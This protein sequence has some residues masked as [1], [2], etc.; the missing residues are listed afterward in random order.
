MLT[1]AAVTI[2]LVTTTD[3]NQTPPSLFAQLVTASARSDKGA[4]T[5]LLETETLST[6]TITVT[7]GNRLRGGLMLHGVSAVEITTKLQGCAV[8][9]WR[10]V[11][12]QPKDAFVL[13]ECPS[14]R[15]PRTDCYFYSYR[16]SMLDTRYHPGNLFIHEM[17]SWDGRCGVR[18][19]PPPQ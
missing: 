14:K 17:P 4:L 13:W 9:R 15:V 2:L 10:D 19:P 18:I 8:A 11:G 16:A 6:S 3:P 1:I 12:Q 5:R 7:D